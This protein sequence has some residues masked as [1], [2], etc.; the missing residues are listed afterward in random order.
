[1]E[2]L[3]LVL[4]DFTTWHTQAQLDRLTE[5]MVLILVL[6]DF[7]TWHKGFLILSQTQNQMS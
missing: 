2:V 1:M 4:V 5:A 6:V 3:I 7:T